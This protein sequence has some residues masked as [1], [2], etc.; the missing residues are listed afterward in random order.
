MNFKTE[1]LRLQLGFSPC[2]NDTFM[3]D[4]LVHSRIDTEGLHF[5]VVMEDV[6]TLNQKALNGELSVSKVSFAAF[7]R[8]TDTYQMLNAGSAMGM[9]VGPLLIAKNP[10]LWEGNP[11]AS[12][13]I[14]GK[15][16]TANFL[17]NLFFP[18]SKNKK[19]MIFSE[20]ENAV[21]SGTVDAG[22]IIHE[23]R[24][25]YEQKGLKKICDLGTLWENETGLPIPLG[26]IAVKKNL[27]E[28]LKA[29]IDRVVRRSI[30]FAFANP[31][32]SVEYVKAHAQEMDE[33]VRRKHIETYVNDFSVDLGEEGRKAIE[34]L[35][36]KAQDA[37]LIQFIPS[38][39]FVKQKAEMSNG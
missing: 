25:T 30:E 34:V 3:F 26:G 2:P 1:S 18:S 38:D 16:T 11:N 21:L 15:N 37:G 14:P 8:M 7:T 4:A 27:P 13:A 29:K 31:E 22:V 10:E 39:I 28:E 17:F 32:S 6:E 36:H 9:G 24:F 33:A 20:I 5:E 23:N 12:V 19:E 35:F